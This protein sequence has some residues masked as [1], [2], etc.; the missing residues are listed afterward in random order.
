[1]VDGLPI[2]LAAFLPA[3]VLL[4]GR[5]DVLEP[6]ATL[7]AAV[8]VAIGQLGRIGAVVG[9][10]VAGRRR[11]V[12]SYAVGTAIIG[13][14]VVSLKLDPRALTEPRFTTSGRFASASGARRSPRRGS[15]GEVHP[16]V[17]WQGLP[18]LHD[19]LPERHDAR[20]RPA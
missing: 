7:W 2:L 13:V 1:M 16:G 10:A 20:G 19:E 8:A 6:R 5:I 9:A 4:L 11:A 17:R 12:W 18:R 14:A 15:E 3:A